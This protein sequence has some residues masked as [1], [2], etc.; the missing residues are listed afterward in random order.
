MAANREH[1]LI[2]WLRDAHGMEAATTDNRE[3]LIADGNAA[4]F[5]NIAA[6]EG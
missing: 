4:P 5:R 3:R 6:S 2:A 1:G